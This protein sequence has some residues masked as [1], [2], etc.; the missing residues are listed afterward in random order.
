[1]RTD[2]AVAVE[3]D[4]QIGVAVLQY[5]LDYAG[6]YD[7]RPLPDFLL[8]VSG[9]AVEPHD[10]NID[11]VSRVEFPSSAPPDAPGGEN[12]ETEEE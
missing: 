7:D 11:R 9:W 3:G 4:R 10:G 6:L 8:S 2:L 12:S 5:D 1:M